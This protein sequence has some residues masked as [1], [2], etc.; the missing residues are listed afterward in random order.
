MLNVPLV[1]LG[2]HNSSTLEIRLVNPGMFCSWQ[3]IISR[4]KAQL[5]FARKL[6][7]LFELVIRNFLWAGGFLSS[8]Q[9]LVLLCHIEADLDLFGALKDKS[10][11]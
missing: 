5:Y 1:N 2:L 8:S 4:R 7:L 10:M 6:M 3:G 9:C 11:E